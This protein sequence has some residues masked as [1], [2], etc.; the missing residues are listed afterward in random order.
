ME[1]IF[2]FTSHIEGRNAR[3][4]LYPDRIEWERMGRMSGAAK[5]TL[6]VATGGLSL[7]ATGVTRK[8]DTAMLP[9]RGIGGV[10]TH[11]DG[12]RNT[13]VRVSSAAQ[14]ID[15]RISHAEAQRFV[16]EL[17]RLMLAA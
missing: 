12:L 16:S 2:E 4:R 8:R 11:K 13:L 17:Q 5:A 1:P 3:V 6:G 15:F 9:I 14:V 7:I 10:T